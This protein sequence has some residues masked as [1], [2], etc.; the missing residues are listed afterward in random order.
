MLAPLLLFVG[1]RWAELRQPAVYDAR[2]D[3]ISALAAETATD[4]WLMTTALVGLGLCHVTSALGLRAAA[5]PGRLL[6][7]IGGVATLLV[8]AFPLPAHGGSPAHLAA[9]SAAFGAL[10][11]WP[12]L[13]WPRP[14]SAIWALRRTA[15][16]SASL[17]L[18]AL[19][20]WL[21]SE[22]EGGPWLGLA[23]RVVACAEALWPLLV[24]ASV[25][26]AAR[27]YEPNAEAAR[28]IS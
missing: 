10:A 28:R 13:A 25:S 15:S 9:A 23:E 11:L 1:F 17:V 21:V 2:V 14:G 22:L 24:V 19:L 12:A 7:A 8:A 20:A 5:W 4:P 16:M 18:C 26:M 6:L 3:T 27:T